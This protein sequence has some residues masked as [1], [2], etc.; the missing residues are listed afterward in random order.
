MANVGLICLIERIAVRR[1]QQRIATEE[2]D[3]CM[4]PRTQYHQQPKANVLPKA[5]NKF[6]PKTQAQ[7]YPQR[8]ALGSSTDHVRDSTGDVSRVRGGTG[9]ES[10][11]LEQYR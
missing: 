8:D 11:K 7:P 6:K 3:E 10:D 2:R 5:Y 4:Y 9:S 1:V